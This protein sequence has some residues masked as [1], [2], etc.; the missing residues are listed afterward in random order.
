MNKHRAHSPPAVEALNYL[1]WI[2]AYW[3]L[4]CMATLTGPF[5]VL[6]CASLANVLRVLL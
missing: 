3:H 4:N 5:I 1:D 6:Q 2:P